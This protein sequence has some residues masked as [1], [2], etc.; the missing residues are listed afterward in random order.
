VPAV[1]RAEFAALRAGVIVCL[2]ATAGRAVLGREVKIGAERGR[3][4]EPGPFSDAGVVI[5]T[6]PSALLR[7]REEVDRAAGF[8]ALV[9]DLRVAAAV[10]G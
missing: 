3:L 2:G 10:V 5:T 4:L 8:D 1:A 9:A 6:H 7:L